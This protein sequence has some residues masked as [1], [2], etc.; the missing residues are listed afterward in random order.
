MQAQLYDFLNAEICGYMALLC[1]EDSGKLTRAI[2][3]T[4]EMLKLGIKNHELLEELGDKF[5]VI[6]KFELAESCLKRIIDNWTSQNPD[7]VF[8]TNI[9]TIFSKLGRVYHAQEK[10]NDAKIHYEEALKHVESE[11]ERERIQ[12]LLNQIGY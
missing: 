3:S 12:G 8:T 10:L 7:L 11:V 4:K 9:G 1:L 2:Q 5:S 6:S